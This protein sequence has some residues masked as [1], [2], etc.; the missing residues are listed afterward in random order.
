MKKATWRDKITDAVFIIGAIAMWG[1]L[2][3]SMKG[4]LERLIQ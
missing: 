3:W 2:L 1:L 4:G